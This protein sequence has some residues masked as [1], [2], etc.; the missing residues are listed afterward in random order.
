MQAKGRCS[1]DRGGPS[2]AALDTSFVTAVRVPFVN[3]PTVH[4]ISPISHMLSQ[5]ISP[6]DFVAPVD[7]GYIMVQQKL[8]L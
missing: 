8:S 1:G 6:S 3:F 7:I 5:T 2:T 4:Q